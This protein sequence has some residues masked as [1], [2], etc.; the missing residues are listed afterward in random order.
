MKKFARTYILFYSIL[1]YSILFYSILF[2]SMSCHVMRLCYVM[3][4]NVILRKSILNVLGQ[5]TRR[6]NT[7]YKHFMECIFLRKVF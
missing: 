7:I 4:R 3:L 5:Q 2:Y 1:F 6:Q